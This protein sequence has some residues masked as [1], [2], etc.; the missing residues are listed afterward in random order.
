DEHG[1]ERM[2]GEA[3]AF[4]SG[5]NV[6]DDLD[7]LP[8]PAHGLCEVIGATTCECVLPCLPACG[9]HSAA[10][11]RHGERAAMHRGPR[12]PSVTKAELHPLDGEP[13]SLGCDLSH[14]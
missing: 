8:N 14:G 1:P 7:R 10:D 9:L 13:E 2:H 11:T 12:Q 3:L 4:V 6:G 5:L